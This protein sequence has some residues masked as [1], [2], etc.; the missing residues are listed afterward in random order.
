[1]TASLHHRQHAFGFGRVGV[2][3]ELLLSQ[4]DI[5]RL[6]Q[7][8]SEKDLV[9][10]ISELK[11]ASSVSYS[12]NPHQFIHAIECW[13]ETELRHL[14]EEEDAKDVFDILWM[15]DDTSFVSYL[16][17]KHHGL[18]SAIASEPHVG[19]LAF[20][21]EMYQECIGKG[22]FSRAPA[23]LALWMQELREQ[24]G[25]SPQEIDTKVA[26]QFAEEQVK[27]ATKISPLIL[28][29]VQHHIDLQNIRTAQRLAKTTIPVAPYLLAGGTIAK[30]HFTE[31][32]ASLAS[33]VKNSDLKALLSSGSA[34]DDFILLERAL[35]KEIAEDLAEMRSCILSIEPLFAFGAIAVSQ[36]KVLRTI[37]VGKSAGL[38]SDEVKNLLPPFLSASPFAA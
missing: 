26:E 18:T 7:A 6:L 38:A 22:D 13:L 17:K 8:A 25:L 20:S 14:V 4:A 16:L 5:E 27:R 34:G 2:L 12:S 15:K 30:E 31:D 1:M 35:V 3:Q 21:K 33:V 9:K 23:S 36:L 29:Y 10:V 37:L 28:R 11:I 32:M 24:S 19:A